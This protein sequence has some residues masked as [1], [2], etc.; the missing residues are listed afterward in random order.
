MN[1]YNK[2]IL[3]IKLYAYQKIT[4]YF[5]LGCNYTMQQHYNF[6]VTIEMTFAFI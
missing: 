5:P 1:D 4:H 2:E 3:E 6:Q